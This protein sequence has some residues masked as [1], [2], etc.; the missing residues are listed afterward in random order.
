[1]PRNTIA[2]TPPSTRRWLPLRH[3]VFFLYIAL[4]IRI[5]ALAELGPG[6]YAQRLEEMRRG[7]LP[8]RAAALVMRMDPASR[9]L[10]LQLRAGLARLDRGLSRRR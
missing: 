6:A 1:M 9:Q 3:L 4:L 7:S 5:L 2:L 8:E 10:A